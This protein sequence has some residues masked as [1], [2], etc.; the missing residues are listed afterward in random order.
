MA[1]AWKW[2]LW[3][4]DGHGHGVVVA[5][6][7][8][9]DMVLKAADMNE[10]LDDIGGA[11]R[12]EALPAGQRPASA[13]ARH[14]GGALPPA[15]REQLAATADRWRAVAGTEDDEPEG[16]PGHVRA[17]LRRELAAELDAMTVVPGPARTPDGRFAV[18]S[19]G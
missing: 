13:A 3:S 19:Q 10:E 17:L 8:E 15:A 14:Q 18:R 5:S 16:S 1:D 6:G 11:G 7:A 4:I 12:Y 2:N 9:Q